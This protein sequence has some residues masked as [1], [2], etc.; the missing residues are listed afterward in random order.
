MVATDVA[1]DWARELDGL[2][3][4]I[5]ARFRRVEPRRRVRVIFLY[6]VMEVPALLAIGVWFVFQLI[7]GA[8]MLGGQMG[9]VAY[10]A[11]IGGFV[12]GL[13]LVRLFAGG[14]RPVYQ[15]I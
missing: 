3:E 14:R 7:S 9:G 11:H 1:V 10:G 8:G 13:L 4:R 5:V 6:S 15:G 2:V 12:A